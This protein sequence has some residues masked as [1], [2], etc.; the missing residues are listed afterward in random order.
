MKLGEIIKNYRTENDISMREFA[1]KA[2]MSNAYVSMLEKGVDGRGKKIV[3]SIETINKVARACNMTF[4]ALFNQLDG[5][6]PVRVNSQSNLTD[7]EALFIEA[8]RKADAQ[9]QEM[10]KRLLAYN[11]LLNGN[12]LDQEKLP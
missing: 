10:I 5:D 7:N 9:T 1:K 3:P 11:N 2:D 12:Q 8:Y 4:D 6:F